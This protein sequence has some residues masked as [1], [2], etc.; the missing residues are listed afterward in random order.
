[1]LPQAIL[2]F[3]SQFAFEPLV[4]NK[5]KLKRAQKFLVCGMGGSHL[6]VDILK[7]G[8]PAQDIV[9]WRDYGLPPLRDLDDRLI[10]A[11]SYS[12][13]TEEA[14]ESL[15]MAR[16]KGLNVAAVSIGGAL[17]PLAREYGMPYVVIPD[18]GIQP[19]QSNAF[20]TRG[21]AALMQDEATLKAMRPLANL[22]AAAYEIQG[23]ALSKRLKGKV[24]VIYASARNEGLARNW[25]IKFNENG[26]IP[27]YWNSFPEL[28]HNEINGFAATGSARPLAHAFHFVFLEDEE[29]H[30]QVRKRMVV[31]KKLYEKKGMAVDV[32]TLGGG[33]R[34]ERMFSN[35]ILADWT[36]YHT[37]LLYGA[38]PEPV[39][40][41]EEFKKLI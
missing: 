24:P 20:M 18:T 2:D 17:I 10:V 5:G 19:R 32:V 6:P 35:L 26:K 27:A 31:T 16:E 12:G 33:S 21:I 40:M 29:D 36:T 7:A 28:N 4:E 11:S 23:K 41:V 15:E 14:I 8:D 9:S 30:P 39:P 13:N 37:A 3:P 38:E 34:Y 22:D 1:M 25:K